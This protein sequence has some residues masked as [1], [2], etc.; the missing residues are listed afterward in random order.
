MCSPA[1]G[2][3]LQ[4]A[5]G[6]LQ[7]HAQ[8][9]AGRMQERLARR[10]AQIAKRQAVDSIMRGQ[11]E[12]QQKR[13]AVGALVARQRA[14]VGASGAV[15]DTGA[16]LSLVEDTVA[17]G[18]L[19]ALTIENNAMREAWGHKEHAKNLRYEGR[20]AKK[21][22]AMQASGTLLSTAGQGLSMGKGLKGGG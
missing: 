21:M 2:M 1:A 19:E 14:A 5:G 15:V 22:G 9:T 8:Y 20:M 17:V 18:E 13:Q 16:T 12:A 11:V 4:M 6:V 10:N 7:A 3:A